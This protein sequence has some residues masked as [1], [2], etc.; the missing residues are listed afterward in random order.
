MVHF[1]RHVAAG[2]TRINIQSMK[3]VHYVQEGDNVTLSCSVS[4]EDNATL[5][6]QWRLQVPWYDKAHLFF[7]DT[8]PPNERETLKTVFD[9]FNIIQTP[10]GIKCLA[11]GNETEFQ[12]RIA[13]VQTGLDH[14]VLQCGCQVMGSGIYYYP[15]NVMYV[16]VNKTG[17][18]L[19]YSKSCC[20][21]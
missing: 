3:Y 5:Y 7:L 14:S 21:L 20:S 15:N 17:K 8:V 18:V 9:D 11:G 19:Q 10:G 6:P 4:C 2:S 12:L 13:G 1:L 16:F